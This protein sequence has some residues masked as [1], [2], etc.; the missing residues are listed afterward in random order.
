MSGERTALAVTLL[1]GTAVPG[2]RRAGHADGGL[3]RH[4]EHR[5]LPW[6]AATLV[7]VASGPWAFRSLRAAPGPIRF[8]L[9]QDRWTAESP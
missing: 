2:T 4:F 9:N 5:Y 3:R 1:V 8:T 7:S 6:S